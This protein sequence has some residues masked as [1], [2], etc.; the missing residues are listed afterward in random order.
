[1]LSVARA[2]MTNS[3]VLLLDEPTEGLAPNIVQELALL[4]KELLADGFSIIVVEQ[5]IGFVEK[6]AHEI[7]V[8]GKGKVQWS[9]QASTFHRDDEIIY[10]WLGL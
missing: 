9:G 5:N 1:M 3:R 10:N 4:F 7:F 6:M 2:L 8:F